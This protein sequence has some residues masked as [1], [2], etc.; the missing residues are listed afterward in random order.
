MRFSIIVG[1]ITSL[2][3][4]LA[5]AV[6]LHDAVAVYGPIEVYG[7]IARSAF[8]FGLAAGGCTY[9][10]RCGGMPERTVGIVILSGVAVDPLLHEFLRVRFATVDPTHLLID[11]VSFIAFLA[12]SL[13]AHR[14]WPLWLSAFQLLSLGAHGAKAMNLSIHPVVYSAMT[15]AWA[16]GMLFLLIG[17]TRYHQRLR[18]RGETRKSWSDFSRRPEVRRRALPTA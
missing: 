16:Y 12:V 9:A 6:T 10:I 7:G 13:R 4:A 14:F 8:Y 1:L 15:V 18:A 2:L 17:A 5:F 11:S 3:A